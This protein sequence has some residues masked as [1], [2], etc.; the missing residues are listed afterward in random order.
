MAILYEEVPDAD[1]FDSVDFNR[2]EQ[3]SIKEIDTLCDY[4]RKYDKRLIF[5]TNE[6][7]MGIIPITRY[8]RYYR[9]SL[10]RI[11][12]HLAEIS[13]KVVLMVAGIPMTVK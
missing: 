3:M 12:R 1:N 9:D 8:S 2:V 5:V 6:V 10:G 4:A 11:N 7:G 13:D